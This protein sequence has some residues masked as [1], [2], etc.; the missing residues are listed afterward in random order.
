L[1]F[2]SKMRTILKDHLSALDFS[3]APRAKYNL[4]RKGIR[5][6]AHV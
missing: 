6:R 3:S 4:A 1:L 2:N 5:S